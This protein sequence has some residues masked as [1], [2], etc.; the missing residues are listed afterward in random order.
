MRW[1]YNCGMAEP[2]GDR[3]LIVAHDAG[4]AEVVSSW[5]KRNPEHDYSFWLGGPAQGVFRRKLPGWESAAL[6]QLDPS[7]F[8]VI[9]TGTGWATDMERRAMAVGIDRHLRV[10][11]FL[12]HWTHYRERFQHRGLTLRPT[13]IWTG[14][15]YAQDLAQE[16]FP[17][18]R[19]RLVENPYL[20]DVAEEMGRLTTTAESRERGSSGPRVLYICEPFS[21]ASQQWYGREDHWGYTEFTALDWFQFCLT[22][23]PR[24]AEIESIR[25]RPHPAEPPSK[26]DGF[27][28]STADP[29]YELSAGDPLLADLLWADWVVGCESM[30]LVVALAAGKR[31]F[32][33]IPPG[34]RPSSLPHREIVP[35]ADFLGLG[36]PPDSGRADGRA[37]F[38]QVHPDGRAP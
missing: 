2:S 6:A 9:L 7:G 37:V 26:Y 36:V 31:V 18:L 16:C 5:V 19:V 34:G 22:H 35:L 38:T 15:R 24:G 1:P 33:C 23:S 3:Y 8:H 4:G 13:E 28:G 11:A 30:A 20:R 12:D 21:A 25:L 29:R 27:I 17:D 10:F 14:D 32:H